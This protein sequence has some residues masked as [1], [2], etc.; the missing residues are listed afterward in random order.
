VGAPQFWNVHNKLYNPKHY[1]KSKDEE[2][3]RDK[4]TQITVKKR[5]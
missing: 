4:K 3:P 1:L 2:K 5:K